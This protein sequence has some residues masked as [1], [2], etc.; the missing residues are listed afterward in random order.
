MG[1]FGS[2]CVFA[3]VFAINPKVCAIFGGK[4]VRRR[5]MTFAKCEPPR[6]PESSPADPDF[7]VGQE[8]H[9]YVLPLIRARMG[10]GRPSCTYHTPAQSSNVV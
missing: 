3:V 6:S 10:A 7:G 9:A 5:G 2:W 8:A 1:G 4:G